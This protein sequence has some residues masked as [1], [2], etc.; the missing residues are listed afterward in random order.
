MRLQLDEWKG[1]KR[2]TS[3]QSSALGSKQRLWLTHYLTFFVVLHT[4]LQA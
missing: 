2:N 4:V 1:I 3:L